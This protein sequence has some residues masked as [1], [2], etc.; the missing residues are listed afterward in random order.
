MTWWTTKVQAPCAAA[1][2][3]ARKRQQ[4]LT[5]PPGSLGK[6]EELAIKFAGWQDS[7]RPNIE[8]VEICV[9]AGDH[10]V[11]AE[12][13]SAFPQTV[14]QQMMQNFGAVPQVEV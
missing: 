5:K 2:A 8:K 1:T 11:V 4:I 13:V 14:T 9:F 7:S 10:G 6:L 3:A 12:G